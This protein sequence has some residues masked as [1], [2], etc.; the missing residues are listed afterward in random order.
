VL[1]PCLFDAVRSPGVP[2]LLA[3]R[4][5]AW[6][7][8]PL[9]HR[10]DNAIAAIAGESKGI[11]GRDVYVTRKT[12]A[13]QR[14]GAKQ[15]RPDRRLRNIEAG[16]RLLDAHL[17]YFSHHEDDAKGQRQFVDAPLEQPSRL[18][19]QRG[20][21]G[22]LTGPVRHIRLPVV[23]DSAFVEWDQHAIA[24]P[25]PQDHQRLV[26]DDS[27]QPGAHLR[28]SAKVSYVLE[29][30]EVGVLQRVLSLGVIAK[31]RSRDPEK[32]RVVPAHQRFKRRAIARRTKSDDFGVGRR[33]G[34]PG[35]ASR[36]RRWHAAIGCRAMALRSQRSRRSPGYSG[37]G[38]RL[39]HLDIF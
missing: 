20:V 30:M 2:A 1:A 25:F 35:L 14:P 16:R 22:R 4:R 31:H 34:E 36:R 21:R 10:G 37:L 15:P 39:G 6:S 7:A 17:L 38:G 3:R 33:G 23:G 12:G 24:F 28:R 19:T 32:P 29:G 9:Q 11:A 26:N 13:K 27:R 5:L 18:G 8:D